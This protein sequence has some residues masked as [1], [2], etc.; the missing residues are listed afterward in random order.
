MVERIIKTKKRGPESGESKDSFD[1]D[2]RDK[3]PPV[4]KSIL[5]IPFNYIT[6]TS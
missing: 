4:A 3:R 6:D 1:D 5:K 2:P